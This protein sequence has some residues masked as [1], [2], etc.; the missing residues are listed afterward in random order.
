[1]SSN[2][3]KASK[4]V[5]RTPSGPNQRYKGPKGDEEALGY[6]VFD[7]GRANNQNQYNKTLETIIS[8][9][10][11]TYTQPGNII[12]SICNGGGLQSLLSQLQCM[13]TRMMAMLQ[14]SKL[15][16]LSIEPETLSTWRP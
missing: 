14:H 6:N 5:K 15:P 12:T 4:Y 9:I 8:H 1:M 11:R 16:K 13:R 10:G 7:Y 3:K 2:K